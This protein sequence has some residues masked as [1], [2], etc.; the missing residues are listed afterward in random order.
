M[1]PT[2]AGASI[3]QRVHAKRVERFAT[4]LLVAAGGAAGSFV[5]HLVT[6]LWLPAVITGACVVA[7][8]AALWAVRR[9]VH[10]GQVSIAYVVPMSLVAAGVVL[11]SGEAGL[12]SLMWIGLGPT[13]ALAFAGP[14]AA[15]SMLGFTSV[16]TVATIVLVKQGG[17]PV[18]IPLPALGLAEAGAIIGATATYLAM[19]WT[20]ERE[21]SAIIAELSANNATLAEARQQADDASRAKSDFV[22][23]MSHE[24]RT[25][26]N[27]VLGM[28]DAMLTT[29]LP[30]EVR[31]GLLVIRRSGDTLMAILN[32]VLDHSKLESGRLKTER[33]P[34][35]VAAEV[36]TVARLY[37]QQAEERGNQLSV[38][39]E[40][41]LPPWSIGDPLRFRQVLSNLVGNALKFTRQGRVDVMA[42]VVSGRLCVQVRDTGI[43]MKPEM[44]VRLFEPF[45][46]ADVST[47]RRFGGTGLGLAI[48]RRLADAMG[49]AVRVESEFGR[50]STFTI[51]LPLE[52]TNPPEEISR[53]F[54]RPVRGLKVLVAEDNLINQ[55][56][57]KR[58]LE[59]LGH[60]V[61]VANDGEVAVALAQTQRFDVVLMDCHMP[62]VDGYSATEQ[63]RALPSTKDLPIIALT[64]ATDAPEVQRCHA[65]GMNAVLMKP[66]RQ[67][68]LEL[69]L[70]RHLPVRAAA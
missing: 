69:A 60:E 16:L 18:L 15:L 30:E 13:L 51:D 49:G 14:R 57:A 23:V 70:V 19:T 20:Y 41:G 11:A 1:P 2:P 33:L 46:Q 6:R 37:E 61:T 35:D 31:E 34:M 56:V 12:V 52:P 38:G 28:T 39:V 55:R 48:V 53:E 9:G 44:L 4:L 24:I 40:P 22:A 21:T 10:V 63:L 68:D 26:L 65:A 29:E 58:L 36:R 17:L 27:G 3:E 50:G 8:V 5:L 47:T 64:A 42:R 25:P 67:E 45:S 66:V 43:G 7:T 62:V 59:H 54:R 32:D